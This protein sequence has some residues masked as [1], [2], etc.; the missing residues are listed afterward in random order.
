MSVAVQTDGHAVTF[1]IR[2]MP[3]SQPEGAGGVRDGRLLVRVGAA[4]VEGKANRAVAAVLAAAFGVA[5][6]DVSIV[7]GERAR[8]KRVVVRGVTP[9]QVAA[10]GEGHG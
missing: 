8:N 10:V 4:P 6:G 1:E 3:R 9:A 5:R 7:A 2:V